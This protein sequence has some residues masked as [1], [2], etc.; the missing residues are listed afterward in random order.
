METYPHKITTTTQPH[1]RFIKHHFI[2]ARINKQQELG[3]FL[4]IVTIFT[5]SQAAAQ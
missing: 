1:I 4:R 5:K 3:S 2:N